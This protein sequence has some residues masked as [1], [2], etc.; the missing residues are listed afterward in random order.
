MIRV[1]GEEF[2]EEQK[3]NNWTHER[4]RLDSDWESRTSYLARRADFDKIF[5]RK[6][7]IM[8]GL[9]VSMIHTRIPASSLHRRF[10]C[11]PGRH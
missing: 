5:Q 11:S 8:Q 3:L 10:L 4:M 9:P 2:A 1:L 7:W 6:Y